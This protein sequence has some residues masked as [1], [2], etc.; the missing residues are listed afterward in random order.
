M[1]MTLKSTKPNLQEAQHKVQEHQNYFFQIHFHVLD[2]CKKLPYM[3][4]SAKTL[5]TEN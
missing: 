4:K 3:S 5:I 1:Q 2:V